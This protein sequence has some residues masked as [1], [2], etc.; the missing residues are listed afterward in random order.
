MDHIIGMN[1]THASEDRYCLT[2]YAVKHEY[3]LWYENNDANILLVRCSKG[4]NPTCPFRLWA[5]KIREE[6]AFQTK[7][8]SYD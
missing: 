3:D 2:N 6:M 4:R 7:V 8:N 5:S 1:F